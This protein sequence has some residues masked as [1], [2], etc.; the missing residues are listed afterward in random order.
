MVLLEKCMANAIL[1][2]VNSIKNG[3]QILEYI[4][5][6]RIDFCYRYKARNKKVI[7]LLWRNVVCKKKTLVEMSDEYDI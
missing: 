6:N 3:L 2:G 5:L 7:N 1:A 4:D